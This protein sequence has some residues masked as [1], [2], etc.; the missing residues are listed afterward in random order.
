MNAPS[1]PLIAF[2]ITLVGCASPVQL[3]SQNFTV[4]DHL[5]G[6]YQGLASCIYKHL[7]RQEGQ[8]AITNLHEQRTVRIAFT[9][10]RE[11]H[12]ELSFVNEDGGRQTRLEVTS[13][14]GSFPSQHALALA[15]A[16]AA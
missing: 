11:T 15:R 8:L 7:A 16:C 3:L 12:W 13:A 9:K 14:N 2:M 5:D 4:V 10:G 6:S 1:V